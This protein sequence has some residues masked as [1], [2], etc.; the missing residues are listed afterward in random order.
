LIDVPYFDLIVATTEAP[1]IL[2]VNQS[3]SRAIDF[4][5]FQL[6]ATLFGS[7]M[8]NGASSN[9][10]DAIKA[11][12]KLKSLA[13]AQRSYMFVFT[14]GLFGETTRTEL[15]NLFRLCR[16]N[17]IEVFGVGIGR[18][19]AAAFSL[20]SK[21]VWALHPKLLVT[22]L[23]CFFGNEGIPPVKKIDLFAPE[24]LKQSTLES[25]LEDLTEKFNDVCCYKDLYKNLRDRTLYQQSIPDFQP[26]DSGLDG[27]G[28]SNPLFIPEKAMYKAGAFA[29]QRILVCCFW[30]KKIAGKEESDYIDPKYLTE[31]FSGASHC[32]QD[33]LDH[34]GIK[35]DVVQNYKDGMLK[36]Q[37]G[38]YYATWIICGGGT[39]K[40]P[41]GGN[42]HLADQF[43]RCVDIYW[44]SGGA[45]VW[46]CDDQLDFE[47]N[48]W[49]K[50]ATF[51]DV[52]GPLQLEITSGCKGGKRLSRGDISSVKRQVF[53]NQED[54][55]FHYYHRHTL[56]HNLAS[57]FEGITIAKVKDPSKL[58]PFV[59]F[60]YDS[61]GGISALFF[62]SEWETQRGDVIIDCG[63]TKLFTELTQ[64]GTLRYVQNIAALTGQYE[65][66]L[67]RTA[68]ELGPRNYRPSSFTFPIDE[69]VTRDKP[70]RQSLAS[71][72]FDVVYLCDATGSM[73]AYIAAAKNEC[74]AISTQLKTEFKQFEFQFG[75]IFYRDPVDSPSHVHDTFLL[76]NRPETLAAQIG[77]VRASGDAQDGPEDWVG[78]YRLALNNMS[79]RHGQKLIIHLADAPAHGAYYCGSTNHEEETSKLRPLIDACAHR[80]IKI[81]GMPIGGNYPQLS[82][83][84]CQAH[85]TAAKGSLY[86][87]RPFNPG[88][89]DIASI[90]RAFK[91]D[92][93]GA[94]ASIC[95]AAK[96][97]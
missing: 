11:A 58:G 41:D 10:V 64:D 37:S 89:G 1:R 65:K 15:K 18:Y 4:Q 27:R 8:E 52:P 42:P 69:T 55:D 35:L 39:G 3:S 92:I 67:R 21:V 40:L 66:H 84:R 68:S 87:I 30:S 77:T 94:I 19:P 78:A 9:M 57:I 24:Q 96:D 75:A 47:C 86:T 82:F 53:N 44:K 12:M 59:P 25:V 43:V 88:S 73:G 76:T 85:Y 83:T 14:D 46:W 33:V 74:V 34:Y 91:A 26:E 61:E 23:S 90:C 80:G 54:L 32:V 28:A 22:A 6:L 60:S 50:V 17:M 2:A 51:P 72:P 45:V 71:G 7:L 31:R 56:A 29:G 16:D 63:F 36:M 62:L 38:Q 79:W 81:V 97:D 48:L 49:L 5:S 95:A 93:V 20:F 70:W 13:S